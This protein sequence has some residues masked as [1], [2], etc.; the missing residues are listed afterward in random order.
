MSGRL[1]GPQTEPELAHAVFIPM[2]PG[3]HSLA[4]GNKI[5]APSSGS[6]S[7]PLQRDRKILKPE[8]EA[9]LRSKIARLESE[10]FR[11]QRRVEF[12]EHHPSLR[13]GLAGERLVIELVRGKPTPLVCDHDVVIQRKGLR[14]E[15]KTSHLNVADRKRDTGTQ[16]WSWRHVLGNSGEKKFHRLILVG[17]VDERF[18]GLYSDPKSPFVFFDISRRTAERLAQRGVEG[19]IQLTSNPG[20]VTTTSARELFSRF[21]TTPRELKRRYG[22]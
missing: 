11:L 3:L 17:D 9:K 12:L 1:A 2:A 8:L 20:R 18:R 21:Q 10:V 13:A 4:L 15:I 5:T 22:I 6:L 19:M 16:R 14:L 7:F